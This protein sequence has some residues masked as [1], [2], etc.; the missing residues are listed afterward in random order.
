[1]A[2][3][4]KVLIQGSGF[5]GQGHA[6]AFRRAGAEVVGMVSRTKDV[7][8]KTAAILDIPYAGTDW[9]EALEAC[10][11]DIVSLATPGGAHFEAAMSAMDR[12]CHVYSDKPLTDSAEKAALLY[13]KSVECGVKTAYAASYR[14]MPC[15]LFAKDL[16]AEGVIGEPREAESISH[17]HLDPHIPLGWSHRIEQGGGRLNNNFTHLLSIMTHVLGEEILSVSGEVRNDMKK[18]P[19]VK[20]V[21]NFTERRNFI[22]DDINDPSLEWGEVDAEWS[23][24]VLAKIKSAMANDP[25]SI[26]FRH[27]G[28]TPRFHEDHLVFYGSKGSLYIKGHYGH[29]PIY[30]QKGRDEWEELSLPASY[31][32][33][34]PDIED[35]TLRNWAILADLFVADIEGRST[36][37][38]QTFREG[39]LYQ[40]IIDIIRKENHE[41][42]L[43][44][45]SLS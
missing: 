9:K 38:Y 26:M 44:K 8:E 36:E 40:E 29:G 7:V 39:W 43:E 33:A 14:Y 13:K 3:K 25:V 41:T 42:D 16:V 5:A 27:G 34:Q 19:V 30:V 28:L 20:G 24:T 18:A 1:M 2:G 31:K 32:S 10:Q 6:D 12:G 35:D 21:H 11:P 37:S 22:P 23:Y 45:F 15:V 4:Q 17:F